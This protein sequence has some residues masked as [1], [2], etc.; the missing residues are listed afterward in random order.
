VCR[1]LLERG[2]LIRPGSGFGLPGYARIT[3]A[4]EATMR[5]VSDMLATALERMP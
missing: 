5:R 4:P 2:V 3:V 1:A